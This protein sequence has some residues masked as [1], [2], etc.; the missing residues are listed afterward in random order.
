MNPKLL[1]LATLVFSFAFAPLAAFAEVS[2]QLSSVHLCCDSC[3]KGVDKA[4]APVTGVGAVSDK[5]AETV[6]IKA[7]DVAT[8]QKAVDALVAAGYF[9]VSDNPAVKVSA[10]TGASDAKVQ[11]LDV[12]G[13]HLCCKKCVTAVNEVIS[14]V[15]GA[16]ANTATKNAATFQVTGDFKPTDVFSGLQQAGLT[17]KAGKAK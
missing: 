16:T 6:T 5:D 10:V 13:V 8:A 9:G 4:V 1:A 7:P 11:S 2:V 12:S 17:G 15:P 14:K 3:V